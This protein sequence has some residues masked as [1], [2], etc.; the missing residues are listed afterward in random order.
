MAPASP[1]NIDGCALFALPHIEEAPPEP[2]DPSDP[3]TPTG[4]YRPQALAHVAL[5]VT[6]MLLSI[7]WGEASAAAI[8]AALN[9]VASEVHS[10][11]QPAR[12]VGGALAAGH[13]AANGEACIYLPHARW[14]YSERA[15]IV[16][17]APLAHRVHCCGPAQQL[18]MLLRL[19]AELTWIVFAERR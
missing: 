6:D 12:L 11:D 7:D 4:Q 14:H 9:A 5:K 2:E 13:S 3:S 19:E 16:I 1:T 18:V 17:A 15:L 8:A 10:T